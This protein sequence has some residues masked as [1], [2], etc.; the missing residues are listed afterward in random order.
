[1]NLKLSQ[2]NSDNVSYYSETYMM[3]AIAVCLCTSI[4]K[5]Y[6]ELYYYYILYYMYYITLYYT[7]L[8]YIILYCIILYSVTY[9]MSAIAVCLRTSIRRK[10]LHGLGILSCRR[11]GSG[12]R[13]SL[14][15]KSPFRG[16]LQ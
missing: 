16:N 3:S 13:V 11:H 1:M 4:R 10:Y 12:I 8:Y 5:K 6:T 9:M 14:C 2:T 7:V 15:P